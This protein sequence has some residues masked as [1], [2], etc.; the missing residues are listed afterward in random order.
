MTK[1]SVHERRARLLVTCEKNGD[2]NRVILILPWQ[3]GF[4]RESGISLR[5]NGSPA[6]LFSFEAEKNLR[7]FNFLKN[8][9]SA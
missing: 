4:A 8:I 6:L 2:W 9:E 1:P 3:K 5:A 7:W